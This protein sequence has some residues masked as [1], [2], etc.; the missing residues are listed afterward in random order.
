MDKSTQEDFNERSV[1]EVPASAG[2]WR[3]FLAFFGPGLLVAVGYMDPGNWATDLAAGAKFGYILLSVVFFSNL[4]AVLFQ[5]LALKLGI[6]SGKD[7]AQACRHAYPRPVT[8]ILWILCEGAIVACDL[9]EVIGSAVALNLLFGLPLVVGILITGLDAFVI[10]ALQNRGFRYLE[11]LV[12]GLMFIIAGVFVYEI[13]AAKPEWAGVAAGFVPQPQV[14]FN[15]SMLYVAVGI[16]GATVMPH[17]LYLHSSIVQTR[18]FK[19]DDEGKAMAIRFASMDTAVALTI[20]LFI[21]VAILVLS[22]AAFHGTGHQDVADISQA[23]QLLSPTLGAAFASGLF[24]VALLASGQS[25]TLTG[26][27][28]GQIVMEGF[29]DIRIRPWVRRIITRSMAIV[30]ALCVAVWLGPGGIGQLLVLSQVVLSFQL[31]FAVVPLMLFTGNKELMGCFA[32]GWFIRAA[33]WGASAIV[34]VLNGY[35][36]YQAV[37]HV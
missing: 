28:A 18:A 10:L 9:A 33:G 17:N 5:Y 13:L 11:A 19:R 6:A 7:L 3:K 30:P 25:S 24:A 32:N 37:C 36:I 35:L 34:A 22:V 21:N 31:M 15:P 4:L 20:A 14:L 23:Y 27:L 8:I 29:L 12:G 2:F 1:V 16:V 26:T